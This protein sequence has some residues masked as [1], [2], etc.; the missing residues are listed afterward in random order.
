MIT[1]LSR[2]YFTSDRKSA[3]GVGLCLVVKRPLGDNLT[4]SSNVI[5]NYKITFSSNVITNYKLTAP[6]VQNDKVS[7]YATTRAFGQAIGDVRLVSLQVRGSHRLGSFFVFLLRLLLAQ[8]HAEMRMPE[9]KVQFIHVLS[10][11]VE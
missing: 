11:L 2:P 10:D 8:A 5:T 6:S 1:L 9:I 3:N 4:F 7:G